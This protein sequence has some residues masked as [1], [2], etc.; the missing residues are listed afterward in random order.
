MADY[1]GAVAAMRA[2]FEADFTAA[3]V[4]FQN[5]DPP[6][7][8]WPPQPPA[9]WVYFEVIQAASN[10][11]GVGLPGN[12]TWLTTGHVFAH[13]FAPK[14]YALPEHLALAGQAGEV[15][16]AKTIYN[17][18]PGARVTFYAPSVQGGGSASDDG[19]YFGVTVAIPFEFFFIA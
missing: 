11:R 7:T 19:N 1:A 14:G 10:L 2:R 4:V 17:T 3:P 13:V 15:L 9:P 16:R 8:P 5:E 18:D 6:A 12:Q